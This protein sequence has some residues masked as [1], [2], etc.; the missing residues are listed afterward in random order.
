MARTEGR[1]NR[2]AWLGVTIATLLAALLPGSAQAH[3]NLQPRLVEQGRVTDLV[4]DLPPL[5]AGAPPVELTVEAAGL[6]MLAS[7]FREAIG[8]DTRW[9]VRVEVDAP[10]GLLDLVLRAGYSDGSSVDVD[11]RL[12]VLPRTPEDPFPWVGVIAGTALAVA[13]AGMALTLGRRSA[14][15]G[16]R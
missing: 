6:R 3:L 2:S 14:A 7:R 12:T 4:V 9:D 5:R 16:R 1:R 11:E 15:R 13:F 10:P 8:T